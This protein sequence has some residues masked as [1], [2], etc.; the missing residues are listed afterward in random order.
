MSTMKVQ[1]KKL[2]DAPGVYFFLGKNSEILYIGKATSLKDRVASY[3]GRDLASARGPLVVQ[4]ISQ[5]KRIDWK[6]TDSMLE[7]LFLEADLIKKFK[8]KHNTRDKDDKSYNC[9][10]VTDEDYPRVLV[11]RKKDLD[12]NEAKKFSVDKI[13]GPFTQGM[14]LKS[15]LKIIRRLFPY[16]DTCI[17]YDPSSNT[18]PKPCFNAQIGLCS[19]V[20]TG[21][22]SRK[23]YCKIIEN[24]KLFFEGKKSKVLSNLETEMKSRAKNLDFE[25][26]QSIKRQIFS[27]NH[28]QDISLLKTYP[29]KSNEF[30]NFRIESYDIAH[31]GGK[32]AVGVMTV[33]T[34][35][36]VDKSE[37]RKF[38]IKSDKYGSDTDALKEVLTRRLTHSEWTLPNM[39]VVDGGVAQTNL[40]KTILDGKDLDIPVI[41]VQKDERHRP[42]KFLGKIELIET[43]KR[44]IIAINSESHRFAISFHRKR[45]NRDF[46]PV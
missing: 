21:K 33:M 28:I 24:L 20:C 14:S 30:T 38:N 15:A 41:G 1:R 8:P 2:P 39:I 46:L 9:V 6:Q 43:H 7:A 27:L 11:V 23:D 37:Y 36:Y 32:D 17:P 19:G 42:E 5:I 12:G 40:F 31:L 10:V 34:N 29:K 25:G 26:A 35:G 44:E 3:F 13:Y 16:R 4:M 45:R 22:I 18:L